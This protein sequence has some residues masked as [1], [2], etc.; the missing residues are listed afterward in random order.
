[1]KKR[2][3]LSIK[4]LFTSIEDKEI[5]KGISLRISPGEVHAVMGPNG[6]GKSTL[7]YAVAGHPSYQIKRG[8]MY[9]GIKKLN[10]LAPEK[11]AQAGIFLAFQHP[12]A[13]EGVSVFNFLKTAAKAM[14]RKIAPRNFLGE[15]EEAANAVGLGK[16]FLSRSLNLGFSGGER[17]R[18]EVLQ[19]LVLKPKFAIF[20]EI[21][22]GLDVDALR[23]IARQIQQLAKNGAGILVV[24]HYQR[25]L[26]NLTPDKVHVM[27]A[28][29][30]VKSGGP[31]L[32]LQLEEEGYKKYQ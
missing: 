7:A 25:I 2:Q 6:S 1:M 14:G 15:L 21:D 13:V 30:L 29:K 27:V 31:A 5:L 10:D 24:T 20:D 26:K 32:A 11:R 9:L 19:A 3:N 8:S 4:N 16:E 28:G 23:D 18:F 22:S 12:V 17:K